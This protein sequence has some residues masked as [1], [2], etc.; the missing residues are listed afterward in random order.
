MRGLLMS[1]LLFAAA[2]A[3]PGDA[4][5]AGVRDGY[6]GPDAVSRDLKQLAGS[7][8]GGSVISFGTSR[9]GRPLEA[10]QVSRGAGDPAAKPGLLV[11][12]GA[13][14]ERLASAEIALAI[15]R[16]LGAKP[17]TGADPLESFVLYVI[18]DL[19]PDAR[20]ALLSGGGSGVNLRPEDDDHDGA[21]DEDGPDDLNGDGRAWWMRVYRSGG[22]WRADTADVRANVKADPGKGEFGA[23]DL[24]REGKD[25]D[26][27]GDVNE[28]GTGGVNL[29]A[30][31]PHGYE[32]FKPHTGPYQMSESESKGFAEFVIAHPNIGA[33]IVFASDD[34][35]SEAPKGTKSEPSRGFSWFRFPEGI[36]E[37]IQALLRDRSPVKGVLENDAPYYARASERYK[38]LVGVGKE[39][40]APE[41]SGTIGD[42]LRYQQGMFA[43][44]TPGWAFP[45][46]AGAPPKPEGAKDESDGDG[47]KK[48]GMKGKKTESSREARMLRFLTAT[49][50][51]GFAPWAR[52]T[53]PA[54]P[55]LDVEVG[56]LDPVAFQV[57][58]RGDLDSLEAHHAAFAAEVLG[59]LP[60]IALEKPVID[61]LAGGAYRIRCAMTNSGY[62]P[63]AL[64]QGV[65]T[66]KARPVRVDLKL[67]NGASI[68]TG[69]PME[70]VYQLEGGGARHALEWTVQAPAGSKMTIEAA[71]PRA[72]AVRQE[73]TLP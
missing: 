51:D 15:A 58:P 16:T 29:N 22:G 9:G 65:R 4:C 12:A 60:K 19:N 67:P 59:W 3:P 56:G 55:G 54:F 46:S 6:P 69:R 40:P 2:A 70:L 31:F 68:L 20:A 8:P 21:V 62:L 41:T 30:N 17:A 32:M 45:D 48:P 42:W 63:T 23:F 1:C 47:P 28:D 26:S 5:A 39:D 72:G 52:V 36:P 61:R 73:V 53:H 44:V 49:G 24:F 27:D 10:L 11:V 43:L 34:M 57:P 37:N 33:A 50:R 14:P 25:D 64:D 38:A 35:L 18:P 13:E 66:R 7:L 71:S